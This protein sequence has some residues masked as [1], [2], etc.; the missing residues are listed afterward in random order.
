MVANRAARPTPYYVSHT[1]AIAC[2]LSKP[3]HCM[4]VSPLIFTSL[5]FAAIS[6]RTLARPVS[7]IM[8]QCVSI[9]KSRYCRNRLHAVYGCTLHTPYGLVVRSCTVSIQ[10]ECMCEM[11]CV[12]VCNMSHGKPLHPYQSMYK[13]NIL[14]YCYCYYTHQLFFFFV[15]F[16]CC[17]CVIVVCLFCTQQTQITNFQ[18]TLDI[19]YTF[20][21]PTS[22]TFLSV[23]LA[24]SKYACVQRKTVT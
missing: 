14:E 18:F 19:K 21:W 10:C 16:G 22:T 20:I 2:V 7:H 9:F 15:S 12:S 8:Q 5:A 11:V 6:H 1:M 4:F 17:W 3:A 24:A 23:R 13:Y